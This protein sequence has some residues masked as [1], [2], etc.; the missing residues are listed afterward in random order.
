MKKILSG[1]LA[2][3][4]IFTFSECHRNAISGRKQLK[5]ISEDA[6]QQMA[7]Q[8]YRTFLS[9]S[10]VV[11]NAVNRDA[12]M[13]RRVGTRISNAVT[14]Y[15]SSQGK[16]DVVKNYNWEFNLIES[17]EV[18]AWCMPGGKVA[19]YTGL[20]PVTQNEAALAVVMG[21]EIA[22]ALLTH[23]NER[24]SQ[25]YAAQGVQVAGNVALGGNQQAV[26][27]FNSLYGIGAQLGYLLPFSRRQELESDRFG[28]IY[29]AMAGYNP[30]E[31]IPLWQRMGQ[32]AG[33]N[34]PPE[35]LSTHPAEETRIQ[36]LTQHM[37]EALKYYKPVNN[38]PGR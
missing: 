27:I 7:L 18:N 12:E 29:A 38:N 28:L 35:W 13:V 4:L 31:S 19:V 34:R 1:L 36:K 21:H 3:L 2:F 30:Q 32:A 8:E 23:G 22:H 10:K 26:N 25:A 5:L 20:L 15:Y 33:G 24:I 14:E 17:K 11:S 6:L 16:G 9:Q 37:E